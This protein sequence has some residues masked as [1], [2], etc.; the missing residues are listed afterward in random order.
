MGNKTSFVRIDQV[1]KKKWD[2]WKIEVDWVSGKY[3]F[4]KELSEAIL[5]GRK[6]QTRRPIKPQPFEVFVPEEGFVQCDGEGV[7]WGRQRVQKGYDSYDVDVFPFPIMTS[8][9]K[10]PYGKPGTIFEVEGVDYEITNVRVERVQEITPSD[11]E[12][13]GITGKTS[14]SPVRGQPYEQYYNG[15]GLVYAEPYLAFHSLWDTIYGET[16]PWDSNPWV[17]VIEFQILPCAE[18]G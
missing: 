14:A 4:K 16:F 8:P 13:E 15:D 11:C 17:W 1:D 6:T 12:A 5:D 10:C 7:V 2:Q 18:E 3:T 9:A